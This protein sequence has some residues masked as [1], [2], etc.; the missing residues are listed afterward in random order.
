MNTKTIAE[1]LVLGRAPDAQAAEINALSRRSL[2]DVV[3]LEVLPEGDQDGRS[4]CWPS[5]GRGKCVGFK[6]AMP[7]V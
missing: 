6:M 1:I 3:R 7:I 5:S 2:C 4:I